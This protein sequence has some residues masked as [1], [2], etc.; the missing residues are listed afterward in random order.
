MAKFYT[1]TGNLQGAYLR[2]QDAGCPIYRVVALYAMGGILVFPEGA[3]A[4]RSLNQGLWKD[5]IPPRAPHPRYTRC[6]ARTSPS[7]PPAIAA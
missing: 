1:D 2:S 4:F 7:H 6:V 3:G 5:G